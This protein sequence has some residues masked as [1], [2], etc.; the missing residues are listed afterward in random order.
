MKRAIIY[1]AVLTLLASVAGAYEK[2]EFKALISSPAMQKPSAIALS[3]D[4]VFVADMKTNAIF[5]FDAAGKQL[6]K[7]EGSLKAPSAISFGG[8]RLY[9]ADTGNSRIVVFDP[10]GKLLWTFSSDGSAPGQIDGPKGISYGPDGRVYVSNTGGSR[11]EVF[12]SDGIYLYGFPTVRQDGVT[13]LR[14]ASIFASRSGDLLVSDPDKALLHK[15]DRTGKLL[16]EIQAANNGAVADARGQ[17]Y[18]INPKEGKVREYSA[19]GE[20]VATF[21]TKGKGKMEFKNLR[22]IAMDD[23]GLVY[24]SDDDNKK[25]V[26]INIESGE[27]GPELPKARLLDRFMITGPSEKQAAKADLFTVTADGK[28]IA[29]LPEAKELALFDKGTKKTLVREGKLQGQVRSPRGIFVDAKGLIYVADTG[30]DRVQIFN[31]DGTYNNMFGESGSGDGQFR[32]P[33]S[34]A[35]NA[36]GNIYVADT[37]NKKIKAFSADGMFLFAAGPEMGN[38]TLANPVA[39]HCDE[40]KNVYILDSVLKKVIVM[41]SMGKFLRLWDDSGRL[42]D[43]ASLAY[44]DKGFFYILDKGSFNIKIFDAAGNFTSSFFAK[45]RGERELWAPQYLAF[46]N[47]KV[48]ISDME[49]SRLLGFDISYL[50]EEPFG[51]KAAAA[52][53]G[54]ALS[55]N[56]KSNAWTG[57]FKVYRTKGSDGELKEL[58]APKGKT[59]EDK[60]TEEATYYYYV[61]GLSVS[62]AQ[63]GLSLP[64]GFYYKPPEAPAAEASAAGGSKNV[65]PMEIVAP[66]LNYIF[67]ANYKYYQKNPVGQI[68][69]KNNTETDFSN[70]KLS[71]FF[72]DFMDFPSDTV[73][74]EVKAGSQVD[75]P[76]SAT[77]NNRIL[78][79]TE[80]TPI[81]CQ[82]TLTYYQDGEEKTFTL[83][84]PVKVLSKNAIV[85]D[86]PA[87]LAN[88]ITP[89]DTPV[90]GFSRFAL[91]E[92][93][94]LEEAAPFLNENTLTSLMIWEALGEQGLSY[95]ADPVSPYA[96]LK[97][98]SEMVLDTVQFPRSTLKLKSGDCDDLT[99]LFATLLEAS[100]PKTA[101]LDYPAH[102]SLMFDTGS[103]DAREV[104][105]PEEYLIKY[106]NTFWVGLEVTM[107]GKDFY[108]AVKHAASFY[109]QNEK[110]VRVIEVRDAWAEFEPV[111]LPEGDMDS[112]P[113]KAKFVARVKEAAAGL[114]KARYAYFKDYFGKVLAANPDD[115]DANIN[116]GMLTAQNGETD[117]AQ[118]YFKAVLAKEPFNAAALNNVGNLSYGQKRY[119]EAKKYY[120]DAAKADPYDAEIWLNLARVSDKLEKKDDV[121]A[122]AERAAK[123]DPS[124]KSTGDKLLK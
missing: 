43:P 77:L 114:Q 70:V 86:K 117:E 5:V 68:A 109:R 81:Q 88:F 42:Q 49:N 38:V 37:K 82:L 78:N 124:V 2:I 108:D 62:G 53:K 32:Q 29:W 45:G 51:I 63:G 123:I 64:A 111:T 48:Y 55:W 19:L 21:G 100:G 15:Y 8:G 57:G 91:N 73:V 93:G 116:L 102:I 120:F 83:N 66:A 60:L 76:L 90:F 101:L 9:V 87:R 110:D 16:K 96:S 79:I 20:A 95:L 46:R 106:K 84:K 25:V 69:V 13:K 23:A 74:P 33:S 54:A 47:D 92:K 50:P 39:V 58:G 22:D 113:D 85:W 10:E 103:A 18:L 99:A 12:N 44:D 3:K 17:I 119:D 121:K 30:N 34:V 52:E 14:P 89:K 36:K 26:A 11:V 59:F 118:K 72:K 97:S 112:Y 98:S 6:R 7:I 56:A 61:A 27:T 28:V 24:L 31:P 1:S 65:A 115:V 41:D 80:D 94:K 104:G 105:I 71:F 107:V 75:V 4:K 35:V 67:S 122:F 40:A